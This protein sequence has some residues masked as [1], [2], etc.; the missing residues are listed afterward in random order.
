MVLTHNGTECPWLNFL[1]FSYFYDFILFPPVYSA[2]PAQHLK[3]KATN[4]WFMRAMTPSPDPVKYFYNFNAS[5]MSI[6]TECLFFLINP[7]W[8]PALS[9]GGGASAWAGEP[10]SHTDKGW[11]CWKWL[12]GE[13]P[14]SGYPALEQA[15]S[16]RVPMRILQTKLREFP[17]QRGWNGPMGE[18]R[19]GV[20]FSHED[21]Q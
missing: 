2:R 17:K 13:T 9:R 3:R 5:Q 8:G 20:G 10:G 12:L 21:C 11:S 16:S 19:G 14:I 7:V 4:S 6:F 15:L 1:L 18:T